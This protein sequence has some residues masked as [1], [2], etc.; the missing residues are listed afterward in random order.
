MS[1]MVKTSRRAGCG[2]SA[3]PVRGA[4][5][6]NGAAPLGGASTRAPPRLYYYRNA[7]ASVRAGGSAASLCGKAFAF[8]AAA[9]LFR[10]AAPCIPDRGG[11]AFQAVRDFFTPP[12]AFRTAQRR[13]RKTGGFRPPRS[14]LNLQTVTRFMNNAGLTLKSSQRANLRGAFCTHIHQG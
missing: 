13:S 6:G 12:Q 4:G 10:K 2:K 5:R 14:S 7:V 1:L 8:P 9:A 11:T 3:R